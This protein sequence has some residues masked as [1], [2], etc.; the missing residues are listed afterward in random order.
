M[1][2]Q[3]TTHEADWWVRA[4]ED[5]ALHQSRD[6]EFFCLC[7][8]SSFDFGDFFFCF[9]RNKKEGKKVKDEDRKKEEQRNGQK[10]K[11]QRKNKKAKKE[12][13]NEGPEKERK[14]ERQVL[15]VLTVEGGVFLLDG[16]AVGAGVGETTP[17]AEEGVHVHAGVKVASA[18]QALTA[19][20]LPRLRLVRVDQQVL[21]PVRYYKG[22]THTH[23]IT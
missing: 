15:F 9:D 7:K 22:K 2:L 3:K 17:D 12:G 11:T 20:T 5:T 13:R 16:L 4:F 21:V 10:G 6:G 1:T 8:N 18:Q 23:V 19:L 14:E